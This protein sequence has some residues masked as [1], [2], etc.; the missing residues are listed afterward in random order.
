MDKLVEKIVKCL[1]A[2]WDLEAEDVFVDKANEIIPIIKEELEKERLDRPEL[3]G[4]IEQT[5]YDYVYIGL[6]EATLPYLNIQPEFFTEILALIPDE[7]EIRKAVEKEYELRFNPDWIP[8]VKAIL[9]EFNEAR[10][11]WQ[12]ET[13]VKVAEARKAGIREVVE[14]LERYECQNPEDMAYHWLLIPPEDW[15]AIKSEGT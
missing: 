12:E 15:Q 6:N 10:S 8:D 5:V 1:E 14:K 7:K 11:H 9:D 2:D 13:A 4:K 3:K